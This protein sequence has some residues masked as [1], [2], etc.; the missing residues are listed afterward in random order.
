MKRIS[1]I[2]TALWAVF[3]LAACRED[4]PEPPPFVSE[5]TLL[6]EGEVLMACGEV[7]ELDIAVTPPQAE[8]N[9]D[10]SDIDCQISVEYAG[11][12]GQGTG[13]SGNFKVQE[14]SLLSAEEGRYRI[15]LLD[16]GSNSGYYSRMVVRIA[17]KDAQGQI[18]AVCS[19]PFTVRQE[20]APL[21]H[22][23]SFLQ[24]DN[25]S[26]LRKHRKG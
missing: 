26:C 21:L 11:A 4:L 8:F 1:L 10:V 23:M 19:A 7:S 12:N 3:S 15:R 2:L 17:R 14:V 25:Q 24:K 22:T 20:K 9:Y 6:S 13:P 18:Q 5:V 16:K